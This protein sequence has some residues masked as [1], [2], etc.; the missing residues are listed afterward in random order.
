MQVGSS[1]VLHAIGEALG[2]TIANYAT[3]LPEGPACSDTPVALAAGDVPEAAR[4]LQE[5]LALRGLVIL[6]QAPPASGDAPDWTV[7]R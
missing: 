5:R 2:E 3:V 7:V 6:P 1:Y 4:L